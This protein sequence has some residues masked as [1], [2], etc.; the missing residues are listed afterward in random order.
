[1]TSIISTTAASS[2][3]LFS[4]GS[5]SSSSLSA[6]TSATASASANWLGNTYAAIQSEQNPSGLL[7][8]LQN[9]GGNGSLTSFLNQSSSFASD[10]ATISQTSVTNAGSL[11]AQIAATNQQKINAQKLKDSLDQLSQTQQAVLPKNVLDPTIYF[12]NGSTL[13]TN[14]NILTMPDG[15]QYDTTTGAKYVDPASI[16]Q[17]TNG[18]YLNTQ[19]N[20]LTMADGTQI[21][22]VTGLKVSATT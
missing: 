9:S 3:S 10:L 4:S 8:M 16:M 17:L 21:D 12:A 5:I 22:T 1:M 7:G 11:V 19:T 15:T 6:S 2:S 20:I 18:A 13:D 14:S